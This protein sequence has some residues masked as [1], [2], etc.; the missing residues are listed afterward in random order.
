MKVRPNDACPCG[1]GRK[2]KKCHGAIARDALPISAD[3]IATRIEQARQ[4]SASARNVEAEQRLQEILRLAPTAIE[5]WRALGDLAN[6][7]R[8][9]ESAKT[10]YLR[11]TELRPDDAAA[12]FALGNVFAAQLLF[13]QARDAYLRAIA[14]APALTGAW[15]NLGNVYKYLGQFALAIDCYRKEIELEPDP[16]RR[17]RRHSNLLLSLHYD[18]ELSHK[19]MFDAH[20]EWADLYARPCYPAATSISPQRHSSGKLKIGYLS[21]SMNGRIVGHFLLN[22]L[23]HHDHA[24]FEINVY[25]STQSEDAFSERLRAHCQSWVDISQLDDSAAAQR[26]RADSID[27]LVDLDGHSPTGRP[28][29]VARKPAPVAVEWLDW[30]DTTGIAVVDFI[31]TD[32]YTTPVDSPQ[33]FVEKVVRLPYSRFCYTPPEHAPSVAPSPCTA[34]GYV[35]FGSF[36]RQD[37]IHPDLLRI[38][39]RI[40]HATPDA[41]LL[42]KNRALQVPAVKAKVRDAFA[43][44]G[45][46]QDRIELRGPSAHQAMLAE[47]ADVD[48]ALDTFP[49]NG[50]LTS[51]ECLWMGVPI[52][53]LASGRMVGRQTAA[54]QQLLGLDD[55]IAASPD[56]YESLAASRARDSRSLARLRSTLRPRMER[57]PLCDAARFA[58]D[59]EDAFLAMISIR[60][61][62]S[63]IPSTTS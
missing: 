34:R 55:W 5:A 9:F 19:A 16:L 37:K 48:L 49:Y 51:F 47:Y 12:H 43:Q 11:I 56:A 31:L 22:V 60:P 21:G 54:M 53:T 10:C 33:L 46:A 23:A 38:W 6:R 18:G 3:E 44:L 27:I 50:G 20:C 58:R 30:F 28:L 36:N 40:L 39:S 45:I 35:T 2:F 29:V 62:I 13:D 8:D 25:S 42:L 61:R 4:L 26:I 1:S 41:R 59:L 63:P 14:L 24:K 32:P 7:A 57:S 15:G 52:V 17:S